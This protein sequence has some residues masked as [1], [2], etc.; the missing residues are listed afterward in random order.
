M[1]CPVAS[2]PNSTK[3]PA[4]KR[5]SRRSRAESLPFS[6]WRSI[7]DIHARRLAWFEPAKRIRDARCRERRLDVGLRG[8]EVAPAL[9]VDGNHS[10]SPHRFGG[11]RPLNAVKGVAGRARRREANAAQVKDRDADLEAPG[12]PVDAAEID[13]VAGDVE[14]AVTLASPPPEETARPPGQWGDP[15]G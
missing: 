9:V 10:A 13:G 7:S 2:R 6:C 5:R 15:R 3:V 4:S 12:D 14:A 1:L 8:A 11:A